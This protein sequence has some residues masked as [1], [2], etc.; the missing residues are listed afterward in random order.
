MKTKTFVITDTHFGVK[1]NSASWLNAQIG[2]FE[3]EFIPAVK[4]ALSNGDNVNIV[5]CGDVFDSRSSINPFVA[6]K[7]RE[8]FSKMSQLCN[9]YIVAGN[10]DFYSPNSDEYSAL[11]IVFGD[12]KNV[13]KITRDIY[14][15]KDPNCVISLYVPWYKFDYDSL[16]DAITKCHPQRIYCHT[17]LANIDPAIIPLLKDIYII[18]GHIHTLWKKNNLINLGS[19]FALTFADCNSPR[20]YYVFDKNS[21][22]FYPG[23]NIIKFWRFNDTEI[24]CLN[25][26]P[27]KNDY[28][29]LYINKLNL[30]NP[31]YSTK[32]SEL[33][34]TIHNLTVIP[35]DEKTVNESIEFKNYDIE[36]LCRDNIPERLNEK[37]EMIV[38]NEKNQ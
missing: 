3:N 27:L 33:S 31:E 18:S 12:M 21:Y 1:Q 19:T 9:V 2:F 38:K 23:E 17:D 34:A 25:A 22:T 14:F 20:G 30:L 35:T 4:L 15:T 16:S 5:H 36:Q 29:E 28:V 26:E 32:I 11:D 13:T 8:I 24:L 10:H 7:V 37:F 6:Q